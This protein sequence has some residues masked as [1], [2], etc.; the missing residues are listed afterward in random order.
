MAND[1]LVGE[2]G[3]GDRIRAHRE[4]R[5]LTQAALGGL[6]GRSEDWGRQG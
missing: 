1:H 2:V 4:G 5:G 3:V 6:V